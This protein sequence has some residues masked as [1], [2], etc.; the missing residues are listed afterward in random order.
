MVAPMLPSSQVLCCGPQ[1][2][3]RRRQPRDQP[4]YRAA[5][6]SRPRILSPRPRCLLARA[7]SDAHHPGLRGLTLV[8]LRP[9]YTGAESWDSK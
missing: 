2:Q 7:D 5:R 8:S 1:G 9:K 3:G 6:P 4:G